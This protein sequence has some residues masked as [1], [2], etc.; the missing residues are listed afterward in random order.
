M[1]GWKSLGS[2]DTQ[3]LVNARLQ[4][5]WAAQVAAAV[6][7]Q[8][9]PPQPDFS[10]QS[11]EWVDR[12]GALAQGT[13]TAARPFRSALRLAELTL[14]LL[15]G[16]G[17]SI[18][19]LPL[20]GRTVDEAYDWLTAEVEKLLGRPLEPAHPVGTGRRFALA[21]SGPFAEVARWFADADRLLREVQAENPGAS[22]VRCWP[23]HF[24]LAT[25]IALD[26]G[27]DAA[28]AANIANNIADPESAR[29]IGAGL[30]PGDV[31]RSAPYFYV[32][33][34]PYPKS[35]NISGL[36]ALAG[37]G[38]WNTEGWLGAVLEAGT[39]VGTRDQEAQAR[40]FLV[41]ALAACRQ[42]LG[43]A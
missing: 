35:P 16:A 19:E 2:V 29:S 8:L 32:T 42:V 21:D 31:G 24:D 7:K 20:S 41:S 12:A 18:A 34:W 40:E 10:Q 43:S 1:S 4:L 5:H 11:F 28:D 36:P 23:H 38:T 17:A 27:N 26:T 9:L 25:L 39:L 3:H 14:S 6:G 37:G 30:S 15:D 13:V 33:P 22:P